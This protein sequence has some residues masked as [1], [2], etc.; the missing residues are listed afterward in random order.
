MWPD[1]V[2]A[3]RPSRTAQEEKPV[4]ISQTFVILGAGLAGAKAAKTLRAEGFDGTV[5]MRDEPAKRRRLS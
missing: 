2:P 4:R 1:T 3:E 5:E